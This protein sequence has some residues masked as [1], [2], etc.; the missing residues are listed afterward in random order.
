MVINKPA[1]MVV[2]ISA[3]HHTGTLVNALLHHCGLPGAGGRRALGWARAGLRAQGWG[4][5]SAGIHSSTRLVRSSSLHAAA[6]SPSRVHQACPWT[7]SPA[8]PS[9][10][11]PRHHP[12][13]T[14]VGAT[15]TRRRPSPPPQQQQQ[16]QLL[17]PRPALGPPRAGP[18]T[19]P[20]L[21]RACPWGPRLAP[22]ACCGPA[23]CTGWTRAPA[24]CWWWP[25]RRR[26]TGRS[27]RSSRR[28]RS[29][30]S[31]SPSR[32]GRRSARRA[33]ELSGTGRRRERER[34]R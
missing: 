32:S 10:V 29:T 22:P 17:L 15:R 1:G 23:L 2:H 8:G 28:A 26:R 34:A 33:S 24:G 14:R 11:G 18:R 13:R 3:G 30:A 21:L 6:L 7:T 12:T 25:S 4:P 20:R 27:A 5:W 16:Q 9:V 31:T 19:R